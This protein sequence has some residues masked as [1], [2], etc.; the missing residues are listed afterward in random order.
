MPYDAN[1]CRCAN[2]GGAFQN[3]MLLSAA[4]IF[5]L[6][7]LWTSRMRGMRIGDEQ[8]KALVAIA[9]LLIVLAPLYLAFSLPGAFAADGHAS[10]GGSSYASDVGFGKSFVGTNSSSGFGTTV[11]YSWGPTWGWLVALTGGLLILL[12]AAMSGMPPR[13]AAVT[14]AQT[15]WSASTPQTWAPGQ[16][17]PVPTPPAA[18]A[19]SE[20]SHPRRSSR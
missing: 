3:V 13:P 6:A 17:P 10:G 5:L 8:M 9:G 1:A 20:G 12:G 15:G 4:G 2:V 11:S 18:P 16:T 19:P 14:A 7:A